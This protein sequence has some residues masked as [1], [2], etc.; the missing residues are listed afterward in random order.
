AWAFG[1]CWPVFG[2]E[3]LLQ[4]PGFEEA[5]KDGVPAGWTREYNEKLS[6]P[7][8]VVEDAHDGKRA[9]RMMTEEWNYLRPQFLTQAVKLPPGTK[10]VRLSAWCKGQGMVNLVFRF[11]KGEQPAKNEKINMG[12]GELEVPVESRNEFALLQTYEPYSAWAK[13]PEGADGVLVKLGNT[14][15]LLDRLNV[16]GRAWI[17]DAALTASPNEPPA[18]TATHTLTTEPFKAPPGLTDVAPLSRISTEPAAFDPKLLIDGNIETSPSFVAGCD[19]P[20]AVD[21]LFPAPLPIQSVC[22]YLLGNV[23]SL[24]VR[25]DANGDGIYGLALGQAEGL[26]G[27]GWLT[28][29]TE[30]TPVKAIR[31]RPLKSRAFGFRGTPAFL[32]EVKVFAA[33]SDVAKANFGG[34]PVFFPPPGPPANVPKLSLR[35]APLAVPELKKSKF[36]RMLCADLWMWGVDAGKKDSKLQDYRNTEGFKQTVEMARRLGVEGILIDLTNSSCW[37]LMPWP[38]KVCNGTNE[39]HL[40]VLI[41]AL[42]AEGFEAFVEII[43]NITPFETIKWHYPEEETSRYPGMKQYPSIIHGDYLKKNWLAIMD[44]IMACGAD[45]VGLSS[46]EQYYRGAFLRALP[47]DDPGRAVYKKR[48]GYDVPER[49]EDSLK[50]RQWIVLRH[51]SVADLFG[52]W[53]GELKKK[54]PN[55]YTS[56]MLMVWTSACSFIEGSGIPPDVLGAR[57]GIT[58]IGADYMDP[59]GVRMAAAANGWRRGTMLHDGGMGGRYPDMHYYATTLWNV[60]YGSGSTNYWRLNY[61]VDY[62][63]SS[64]L[65]R[66]YSMAKDLDALGVW[67]ARP[68]KKL[69]LLSSRSSMDWWQVKHWYGKSEDQNLNRGAE[70]QRGWFADSAAFNVLQRHGFSGDWFFLDRPDQLTELEQYKVLVVPFAYSISNEAAARVKAAAAKGATVILLDGQQGAMDEWGEP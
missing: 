25:G 24:A 21:F 54:Y 58:E 42:H 48:F 52:Y 17:D 35:P 43:H 5:G 38:S 29:A 33:P 69:A 23:E 63:N 34:W 49:E 1:A 14:V 7:F 9:V 15:D 3:N 44:E 57:G 27:K 65:R 51:E 66:V 4:N 61:V 56:T 39:N 16:W 12:F 67:D 13:V 10:S 70:A 47:A 18:I 26:A 30:K 62:G 36:R 32:S 11:L 53:S 68:P 37:D 50:Y 2:G 31:I 28:L 8:A 41:E 45:G 22:L 46:D 55:V 20:A 59:Y 6:G 19:G 64:A 60:M 40:K